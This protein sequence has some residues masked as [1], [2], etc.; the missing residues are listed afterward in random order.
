MKYLILIVSKE[1]KNDFF[2]SI[3]GAKGIL[4]DSWKINES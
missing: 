1:S 4:Q 3:D 2:I